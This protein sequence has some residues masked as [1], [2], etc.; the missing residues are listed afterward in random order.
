MVIDTSAV[1]AILFQEPEARLFIDAISKASRRAMSAASMIEAGWVAMRAAED[2][3]AEDLDQLMEA[4]NIEFV[5]LTNGQIGLARGALHRFG[6][7]RH[8]AK[9]N[10]GDSFA[11]ALATHLGEPL[12]FKGNDFAQTDVQRAL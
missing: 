9:L 2:D 11:Y 6:K 3:G 10:L 12:L 8:P 4:L 5:P 1:I 7:G